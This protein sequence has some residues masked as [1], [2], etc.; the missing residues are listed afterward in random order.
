MQ[1]DTETL[2]GGDNTLNPITNSISVPLAPLAYQQR[3]RVIAE[4]SIRP[5]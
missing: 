5:L 4:N 3:F 1:V 2:R